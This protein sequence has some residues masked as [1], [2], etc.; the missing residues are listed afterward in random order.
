MPDYARA[1]RPP[2]YAPNYAI[3]PSIMARALVERLRSSK[4]ALAT[5]PSSMA[6]WDQPP[7][8]DIPSWVNASVMGLSG[9][10]SFARPRS[11]P[12][13]EA[14]SLGAGEQSGAAAP[15]GAE[16]RGGSAGSSVARRGRRDPRQCRRGRHR[17]HSR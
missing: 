3:M 12:A 6:E 10:A 13:E 16:W 8:G 15:Q 7:D 1:C 11:R 4:A 9:S 5:E 14:A 17:F 2:D